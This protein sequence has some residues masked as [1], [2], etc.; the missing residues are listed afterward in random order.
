MRI[1]TRKDGGNFNLAYLGGPMKGSLS[2]QREK[3][4]EG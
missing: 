1:W 4:K 2:I 3:S